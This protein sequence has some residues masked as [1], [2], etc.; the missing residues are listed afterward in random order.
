[1]AVYLVQHGLSL[2]K[3]QD[4]LRGLSKEGVA[5]VERIAEVAAGYRVP[6]DLIRHSGKQRAAQ[7]AE[8]F[9]RFLSPGHG[10]EAM[11]GIKPLDPVEPIGKSL[12]PTSNVMLV[13]HL[14]F[15][16]KL[17]CHLTTGH[18]GHRVFRFQNGGIVCLD[19]DPEDADWFIKWTLMPHIG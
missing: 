19:R 4:P 16:E 1:M 17:V 11:D 15:M 12:N 7:T 9:A 8:I 6:V 2:P 13:G 10:V 5:D 14:P 3:E 18:C